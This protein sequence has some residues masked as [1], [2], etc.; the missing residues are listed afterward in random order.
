M[1]PERPFATE[2]YRS[3]P[4]V[5]A[6]V[7]LL[8]AQ[9]GLAGPR[10][11]PDFILDRCVMADTLSLSEF[12]AYPVLLFFFDAGDAAGFGAYPYI[13]NWQLMYKADSVVVIGIHCPSFEPLRYWGNA[14]T[15]IAR[16]QLKFPIG[17]DMER[18]VYMK[19]GLEQLP[20][21]VLTKPGGNIVFQTSD[22]D[23]YKTFEQ[24]IQWTI[25]ETEPEA[26][27]PFLFEPK[28]E[29]HSPDAR[30]LPPTP[31][32]MFGPSAGA[33]E[34]FDSKDLGKYR[35]YTD[36]RGREKGRIYLHGRWKVE[37]DA[38]AYEEGE[39]S[40]IRVIYSGKDVWVLPS[41]QAGTAVRVDVKQDRSYLK[42]TSWGKDIRTDPLG[43]PYI[44]MRQA[45][46]L[47]IVSNP[48]YGTHELQ[49]IPVQGDVNFHYFYFEGGATE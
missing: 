5:L 39:E 46:P 11:A 22:P 24:M 30:T 33:I 40:Y 25:R 49:L 7:L 27:L 6:C 35:L 44:Y 4:L 26:V 48:R 14:A 32:I 42:N 10:T 20:T 9:P 19:Y 34:G 12:E 23:K 8:A 15:A 17:M 3:I 43:R 2:A 47:H 41:F 36:S 38:V 16:A 28:T 21:F 37:Q 1:K 45:V 18:K 31:K 13:R 29:E